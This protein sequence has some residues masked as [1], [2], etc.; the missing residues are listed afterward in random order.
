MLF[1]FVSD[2]EVS[3]YSTFG[4]ITIQKKSKGRQ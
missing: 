3:W 2:V 1:Y 4:G